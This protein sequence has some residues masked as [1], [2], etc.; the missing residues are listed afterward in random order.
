MKLAAE[1]LEQ[2]SRECGG[3]FTN[4]R[5][6]NVADARKAR[7]MS[8]EDRVALLGSIIGEALD[9]KKQQEAS[10]PTKH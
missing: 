2:I 9:K 3:A 7:E 10:Q 4:E 8:T 5:H 1:L 6:V